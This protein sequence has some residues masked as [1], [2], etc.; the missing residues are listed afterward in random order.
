MY[1]NH[2]INR[3]F[4]SAVPNQSSA[5]RSNQLGIFGFRQKPLRQLLQPYL[6]PS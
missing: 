1:T 5:F 3:I 6:L 4:F 2:C